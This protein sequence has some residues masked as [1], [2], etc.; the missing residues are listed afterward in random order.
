[1]RAD[2]GN[3]KLDDG[4]EGRVRIEITKEEAKDLLALQQ[5]AEIEGD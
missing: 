2:K 3:M 1:M 4:R 5:I